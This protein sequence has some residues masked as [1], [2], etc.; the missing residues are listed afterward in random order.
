MKT[1]KTYKTFKTAKSLKTF[2]TANKNIV[3]SP[4]KGDN[5]NIK[6][7][8]D[9]EPQIYKKDIDAMENSKNQIQFEQRNK[10]EKKVKIVRKINCIPF[11]FSCCLINN[12]N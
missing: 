7:K 4:D 12:F 11:H 1:V 5:K 3:L 9:I 6:K 8:I 10:T 2:K